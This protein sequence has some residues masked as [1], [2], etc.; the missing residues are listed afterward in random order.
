MICIQHHYGPVALTVMV[1]FT[2]SL[3]SPGGG[4]WLVVGVALVG[5][6]VRGEEARGK[7][8]VGP[9]RETP[10]QIRKAVAGFFLD[11]QKKRN[12]MFDLGLSCLCQCPQ[13][14]P[15]MHRQSHPLGS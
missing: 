6:M 14:V 12:A 10:S 1:T 5:E 9:G 4:A 3:S 13:F 15:L 2:R 8:K 7:I 11:V